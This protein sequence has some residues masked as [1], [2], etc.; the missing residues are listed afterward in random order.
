MTRVWTD[1]EHHAVRFNRSR[2]HGACR[3]SCHRSRVCRSG[4]ITPPRHG[5]RVIPVLI[6]RSPKSAFQR[7]SS[8][9]RGSPQ[10]LSYIGSLG[11]GC[12]CSRL[13]CQ[14]PQAVDKG[15]WHAS[16][17]STPSS[18]TGPSQGTGRLQLL[19]HFPQ[20]RL[21]CVINPVSPSLGV[22]MYPIPGERDVINHAQHAFEI[23]KS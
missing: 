11:Y 3:W 14:G 9:R 13:R 17:Y 12:S 21:K 19:F 2:R 15:F 22:E 1:P 5:L 7:L 8:G 4:R 16:P 20:L 18:R 10:S 23:H 6:N